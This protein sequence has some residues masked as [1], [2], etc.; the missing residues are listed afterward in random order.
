M[1]FA[2]RHAPQSV[3]V[4]VFITQCLF[5]KIFIVWYITLLWSRNLI[6]AEHSSS[7]WFVFLLCGSIGSWQTLHN[8]RLIDISDKPSWESS[9]SF[10]EGFIKPSHLT[11]FNHSSIRA[12]VW[13]GPP[14]KSP[15]Y[16]ILAKRNN[17]QIPRVCL[18][19]LHD[20]DCLHF[21][22]LYF[23]M[24]VWKNG[25]TADT[26]LIWNLKVDVNP[27]Y[28]LSHNKFRVDSN[29]RVIALCLWR[30]LPRQGRLPNR[31]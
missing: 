10:S 2:K 19:I 9:L 16:I 15:R 5:N 24:Y 17:E 13:L 1:I 18:F 31:L 14:G 4:L 29:K 25:C 12:G 3:R 26:F 30:S 28:S 8:S 23:L 27:C 6:Q 20:F 7:A 11:Q 22:F 21:E